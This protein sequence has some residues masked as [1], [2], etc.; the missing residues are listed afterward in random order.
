MVGLRAFS[1]ILQ[2]VMLVVFTR[3]LFFITLSFPMSLFSLFLIK[4]ALLAA[5][6]AI[7]SAKHHYQYTMW[8]TRCNEN[9]NLSYQHNT[10]CYHKEICSILS[11]QYNMLP[12]RDLQYLI[13]TIQHVA[14]KRS[15]VSYQHN[16]TCYHKEI[17]SILS[18]QYNMLP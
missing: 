10:T 9:I 7:L 18:T 16:T 2:S 3:I 8:Y 11:T 5:S 15:A 6:A 12:Q 1:L 4:I 13:N 14:I 17:C